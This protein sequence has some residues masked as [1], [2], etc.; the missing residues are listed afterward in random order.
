M[1]TTQVQIKISLSKRLNDLITTKAMQFG[2]PVT[3]FV[4][5]LIVKDIE[6]DEYPTFQMSQRTEQKIQEAM[7][8]YH[9]GK[10]TK[11]DNVSEFFKNL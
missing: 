10:A 7:D 6:N 11:V 4:K 2:V 1:N 8:D 9:A 3:Q 5:Y